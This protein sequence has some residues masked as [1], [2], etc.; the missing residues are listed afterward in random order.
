MKFLWFF[1]IPFK[2]GLGSI[3]WTLVGTQGLPATW[4]AT[5]ETLSICAPH[6]Q[7][8]YD[9]EKHLFQGHHVLPWYYIFFLE[10]PGINLP[11]GMVIIDHQVFKETP[12]VDHVALIW[13]HEFE[14]KA[15]KSQSHD[16]WFLGW[17][18]EE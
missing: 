6:L 9:C 1:G 4:E 17:F 3:I 2:Q 7:R 15:L 11:L 13:L 12:L 8:V 5:L 10:R 14:L 16:F 18:M